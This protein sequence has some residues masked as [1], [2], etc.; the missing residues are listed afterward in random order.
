MKKSVSFILFFILPIAL[1]SQ[2]SIYM[3]LVKS[4]AHLKG[5]FTE[6]YADS[7]P[8][9]EPLLDTIQNEMRVALSLPGSIDFPWDRLDM[10]G[11]ITSEDK[12]LRVFTWHFT[13]DADHYRYF[14]FIQVRSKKGE[15]KLYELKD[16]GKPQRGVMKV[17]QSISDWYGKLYYQIL[18]HKYKRKTYYTLLG[19][20]FNNSRSTIKS[21]EVITLQR[22]QPQF[23][24]S[25][26]YNG[27]EFIDRLIL[28]YDKQVAISLRFDTG[29]GMIAFDHLVPVHPIYEGNY[30]FYGPDGSFDGLEFSKGRW[31]FHKD[32]DTRNLD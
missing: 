7:L 5:L 31:N 14:G 18:T 22:N 32:I 26:L 20:D 17:D 21:V 8:D 24:R 3:D 29:S 19:M 6:L 1:Y 15:S 11:N 30:E 9:V 28:E 13:D 25:L 2:E 23:A 10:I 12:Q 27:R 16:N 4:E